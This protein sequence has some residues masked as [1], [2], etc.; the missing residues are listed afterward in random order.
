MSDDR[1]DL[2]T[3]YESCN[4]QIPDAIDA[5]SRALELDPNNAQIK[6]RLTALRHSQTAT[7]VNSSTPSSSGITSSNIPSTQQLQRLSVGLPQ[8]GT[9]NLNPTPIPSMDAGKSNP[10][11]IPRIQKPLDNSSHLK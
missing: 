7:S 6:Q 9:P 10:D 3:L 4:N 2:G 5:Y 8:V 1:Y 11:T